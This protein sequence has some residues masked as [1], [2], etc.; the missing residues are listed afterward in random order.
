V[1]IL[2]LP[3]TTLVE[4]D[5]ATQAAADL[6]ARRRPTAEPASSAQFYD[7]SGSAELVFEADFLLECKDA[8]EAWFGRGAAAGYI[9]PPFD[10]GLLLVLL[11]VL[12]LV[13]LLHSPLCAAGAP[14]LCHPLLHAAAR[15]AVL[16]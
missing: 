15:C 4:Q 12:V 14:L 9:P 13:L 3:N 8:C 10:L 7:S 11:L 6:A 5:S 16:L 1:A 2:Q